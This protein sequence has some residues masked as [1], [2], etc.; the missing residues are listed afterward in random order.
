MW[1]VSPSA[2]QHG[3]RTRFR[4]ALRYAAVIPIV[5]ASA[6]VAEL[7]YRLTG[8]DRLSAIFIAG[9]LLAAFL[10]GQGPAY[11]AS[12]L[13][14]AAFMFMVDP[15]YTF[16]FGSPDDFN[17][18]VVF[19]AVS[20]L[21]GTLAGRMR[22]EAARAQV[23]Q[24]VTGTMLDATQAFSASSDEQAIRRSLAR[25]LAEAAHGGAAIRDGDDG[26]GVPDDDLP[27]E[28]RDIFRVAERR[29][30]EGWRG[31][32]LEGGWRL[33]PLWAGDALLGVA[34]S[35][36]AGGAAL[37]SEELAVL[38]ILIDTGAAAI[39]RAR[40]AAGKAEAESRARTEDLRNALLSSISHDLRTPLAS[41]LASASSLRTFGADFDVA[42]RTDLAATI[43]EE[44]ERLDAFVANLLSMTRLEAGALSIERAPFSVTEAVQR[45]VDR[46]R[47][48]DRV[49]TWPTSGELPLAL[50]DP[51][52]FE[53]ALG[54]VIENA[55][56]YGGAG[57]LAISSRLAA[58]QIVV[59]VRDEGPGVAP[60][61]VERIFE[62]FY[63]GRAAPRAAGTG[64]G[65]SI[66]RGL[67]RAMDGEA[68]AA[69]R[70]DGVRGLAVT[71]TLGAATT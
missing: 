48:G 68:T 20:L 26:V 11:F 1:W 55:L 30:A 42:T 57:P 65:L 66:V 45:T 23:R 3:W 19:L 70:C 61:D 32:M 37:S 35:R 39:A 49:T 18:L 41:I 9:V 38:D 2:E 34:G 29:A 50:G 15:R 27:P 44:A 69:N 24:R 10:L 51:L 64:L 40:L 14:F 62:K 17:A 13:G 67:M 21:T 58:G 31:T 71:L 53:Q 60:E 59:I 52:L 43:Q 36:A 63:R 25:A 7:F 54:N 8:S 28:T 5:V 22:D 33:R 46:R 4:Q 6:A 12:A 47:V 16:S 56:R